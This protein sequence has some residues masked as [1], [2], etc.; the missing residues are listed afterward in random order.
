MR[1]SG[2]AS[3]RKDRPA[4]GI[5]SGAVHETGI[6]KESFKRPKLPQEVLEK[7]GRAVIAG[8]TETRSNVYP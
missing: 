3:P 7:G 4:P 1:V 2:P 6:F 5:V 8:E